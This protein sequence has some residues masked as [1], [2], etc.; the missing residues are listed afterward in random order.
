MMNE[1]DM[2]STY[3]GSTAA[4]DMPSSDAV[5]DTEEFDRVYAAYADSKRQLNQLRVSRGYFPVVSLADGGQRLQVSASGS[6]SQSRSG[7]SKGK[8]K[9]KGKG[10]KGSKGSIQKVSFS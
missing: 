3:F 4:E 2:Q 8:S 1:W 9:G 6:S 10:K 5:F 7:S